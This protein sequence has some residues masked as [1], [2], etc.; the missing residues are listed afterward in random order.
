MPWAVLIVTPIMKRA[1]KLKSAQEIIF[2]DSTGSIDTTSN[3]VTVL[4][5]VS[6]A[7]AIPIAILIH[8]GES[9]ESYVGAFNLLKSMFPQC[10]G[11]RE[12]NK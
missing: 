8:Y 10:F 6:K 7:G 12:V 9:E 3:T 4:L 5:T 2:I 1:H 11:G